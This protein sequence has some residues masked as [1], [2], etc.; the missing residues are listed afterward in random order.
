MSATQIRTVGT[1]ATFA[2]VIKRGVI[3]MSDN[4]TLTLIIDANQAASSG[5]DVTGVAK[6]CLYVSTDATRTAHTLAANFTPAVAPCS[7]TR[8]ARASVGR[9]SDNKVW[10]AW[11]GVDNGLYV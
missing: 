8:A 4:R 9:G 1:T 10:V 7:S 2:S 6:I 11:Q 5:T 3:T